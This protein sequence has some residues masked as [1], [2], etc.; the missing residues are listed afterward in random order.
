MRRGLS[1][2]ETPEAQGERREGYRQGARISAVS[3]SQASPG[4]PPPKKASRPRG[5]SQPRDSFAAAD[6]IFFMIGYLHFRDTPIW[7]NPDSVT[8]NKG[9][10]D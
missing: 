3:G 4:L 6:R 7:A 1:R 8:F 9:T 5:P 10:M 2:T